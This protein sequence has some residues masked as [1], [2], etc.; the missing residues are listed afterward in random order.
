MFFFKHYIGF[1]FGISWACILCGLLMYTVGFYLYSVYSLLL[2]SIYSMISTWLK[3]FIS[4]CLS[5]IPKELPFMAEGKKKIQ[6]WV[7]TW[8][9]IFIVSGTFDFHP[10][11]QTEFL[12]ACSQLA[13]AEHSARSP[14]SVASVAAASRLLIPQS[15]ENQPA[16]LLDTDFRNSFITIN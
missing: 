11:F 13:L 10:V 6:V 7:I 5:M 9:I 1:A 15:L 12:N 2:D 14:P 3:I 4:P 8:T 16:E